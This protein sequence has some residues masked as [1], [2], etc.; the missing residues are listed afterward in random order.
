MAESPFEVFRTQTP[1]VYFVVTMEDGLFFF[2]LPSRTRA[3]RALR[4]VCIGKN[5]AAGRQVSPQE[6]CAIQSFSTPQAIALKPRL[7]LT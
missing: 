5:S 2:Y 6:I 1:P 7:F 3:L 4:A